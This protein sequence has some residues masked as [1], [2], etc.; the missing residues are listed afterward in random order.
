MTSNPHVLIALLGKNPREA[1]YVIQDDDTRKERRHLF[2][3]MALEEYFRECGEPVN[4][5]IILGTP[6][7]HWHILGKT[8]LGREDGDEALQTLEQKCSKN[9]ITQTDLNTLQEQLNSNRR[10]DRPSVQLRCISYAG[11]TE[12]QRDL[13]HLLEHLTPENGRVTFDLTHSLRHLSMLGMLAAT[14]LRRLKNIRMEVYFGA[15][16]M[17]CLE[18][19]DGRSPVLRLSAFEDMSAL[20]EALASFEQYGDYGV[21][22]SIFDRLD[23]SDLA[24][25][26]RKA[27][28]AEHLGNFDEA[29]RH[30]KAAQEALG[31]L[32]A[33][34]PLAFLVEK[35]RERLTWPEQ[36]GDLYARQRNR[37]LFAL[38]KNDFMRAA[39]WGTEAFKT[40]LMIG[41]GQ[42]PSDTAQRRG[43][44]LNNN[45]SFN[46][47]GLANEHNLFKKLYALRNRL[48]HMHLAEQNQQDAI[49]Q[50]VDQ[51]LEDPARCHS[52]LEECLQQL[53]PERP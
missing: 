8:F 51:A 19:W 27:S 10:N 12:E 13:L 9:G 35:L 30:I 22:A 23:A 20:Q 37:A 45:A 4:E 52:F 7:S 33:Q 16:E 41:M 32:S 14:A 42:D 17:S 25:K 5:L 26:L 3:F 48:G 24:E 1:R 18:E 43:V 21:L 40:R 53:L 15:F 39:L 44:R 2:C 36:A 47:A 11:S 49:E 28:F 31:R 34:H 29:A 38:K 6:S 50:A 46:A